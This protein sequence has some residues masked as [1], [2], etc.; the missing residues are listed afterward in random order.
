MKT[1]NRLHSAFAVSSL[2][3]AVT[4]MTG[5][6]FSFSGV[7]GEG[8]IITEV[9]EMPAFDEIDFGGKGQI[10]LIPGDKHEVRVEIYENL[11][12]LLQIEVKD[13]RLK[14]KFKERVRSDKPIRF[15]ITARQFRVLDMSGSIKIK[16]AGVLVS[17]ELDL[18]FSGASEGILKVRTKHLRTTL[19]GASEMA[20][21]G[22]ADF[23]R[24]TPS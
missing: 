22:T 1:V 16:S 13:G 7:E 6:Q 20:F 14:I 18:E 23:L 24:L 3:L 12:P 5:C 8:D 9:R 4:L 2:L 11:M 19:S 15:Y 17:D 10:A 21:S